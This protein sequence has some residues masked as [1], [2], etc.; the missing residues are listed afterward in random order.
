M[1]N[2][3]EFKDTIASKIKDYLPNEYSDTEVTIN[4]FLKNNSVHLDGLII[5]E[6][7]SNICP[8]IYLNQYML[9]MKTVARLMISCQI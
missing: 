2:Y 4:S 5:R 6:P 3:E 7:G 8:N 1:L 9:T